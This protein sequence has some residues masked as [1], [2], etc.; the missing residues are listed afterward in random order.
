[1]KTAINI[2]YTALILSGYG[3]F[4]I[5]SLDTDTWHQKAWYAFIIPFLLLLLVWAFLWILAIWR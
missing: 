2:L 5:L 4:F 3:A 1:M